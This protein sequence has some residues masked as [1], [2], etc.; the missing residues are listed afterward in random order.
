MSAGLGLRTRTT[1]STASQVSQ[2]P[3]TGLTHPPP[4][5]MKSSLRG[6][7]HQVCVPHVSIWRWLTIHL[8]LC[9]IGYGM[10]TNVS[11]FDGPMLDRELG[12]RIF[13][14]ALSWQEEEDGTLCVGG[15]VNKVV[16][17]TSFSCRH[18]LARVERELTQNATHPL[19]NLTM[20]HTQ[21]IMSH[22]YKHT[23]PPRTRNR[24]PGSAKS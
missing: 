16:C 7:T 22:F 3:N 12:G 23:M 17:V 1:H 24:P 10:E 13:G 15:D 20:T 19:F 11:T 2:L 14:E 6:L 5:G 21:A 8:C 9:H 18:C 4:D